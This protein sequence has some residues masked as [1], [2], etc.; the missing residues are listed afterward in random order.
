MRE[1]LM[2]LNPRQID[3]CVAAFQ[4]LDI[5]RLWIRRMTE[6]DIAARWDEIMELTEGYDRLYMAGDDSIV[7]Q[8]ALDAVRRLLDQGHP[9]ATGYSNLSV[10]DFRVNL[11]NVPLTAEPDP[12][13]ELMTLADVLA[14]PAPAIPTTLLGYCVTGMAREMWLRYPFMVWWLGQS[15]FHLSKRLEHD[16][17]PIVAAREAFVW[18]MKQ[19][20]NFSDTDPRYRIL[21]GH[22]PPELVMDQRKPRK[23]GAAKVKATV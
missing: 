4:Q 21:V 15:D 14:H 12:G 2:I 5:D 3:E 8:H 11:C 22:E 19:V 18:H 6:A 7:R 1:L 23:K 20:W 17:I 9:V 16:Q 10:Q 13:L